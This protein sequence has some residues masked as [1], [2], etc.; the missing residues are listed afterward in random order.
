MKNIGKRITEERKIK[1]LTQEELAEKAKLNLRTIQRI[2][3]NENEP[4][5]KTLQLVFE[6]LEIDQSTLSVEP[7]KWERIVKLILSGFFLVLFN[8]F[9][10]SI[11]GYFTLDSHATEN[12][13]IAGFL[14]SFL[15]PIFIVIKTPKIDGAM[16]TL[17][18]GF[19][20]LYYA[21][22]SIFIIGLPK[23]FVSCLL[24]CLVISLA[25]L[26]FGNEILKAIR[27]KL[28]A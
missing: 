25:V 9:L 17:K 23:S 28:I 3:N 27:I 8:L 22:S 21:I 10:I 19:G 18:F 2:E 13:R 14:V 5:D 7:S 11:I 16:R 12:S 15:I 1:G 24:P 20:Y 6:A 26:Y 4:R